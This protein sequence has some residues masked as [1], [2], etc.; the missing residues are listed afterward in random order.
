MA[1]FRTSGKQYSTTGKQFGSSVG[2][3]GGAQVSAPAPAPAAAPSA[4]AQPMQT[5]A[6]QGRSAPANL[7]N[8]SGNLISAG[9]NSLQSYAPSAA[10]YYSSAPA[11]LPS[12]TAQSSSLSPQAAP[13]ATQA[14]TAGSTTQAAPVVNQGYLG[15]II[16]DQYLNYNA[17]TKTWEG[18][19]ASAGRAMD[20]LSYAFNNPFDAIGVARDPNISMNDIVKAHFE[21]SA[22]ERNIETLG[23]T[24]GYVTAIIAGYTAL[25][26]LGNLAL[27]AGGPEAI[28]AANTPQAAGVVSKTVQAAGQVAVNTAT[29]TSVIKSIVGLSL[30]TKLSTVGGILTLVSVATA[31]GLST[32]DKKTD[33]IKKSGELAVNLK[34]LGMNSEADALNKMNVDLRDG[35]DKVRGYIPIFGKAWEGS[36]INHYIEILDEYDL[37]YKAAVK[38]ANEKEELDMLAYKEAKEGKDRV[39]AEEQKQEQRR[40]NEERELEQRGYSEQRLDESR[41]YNEQQQEEERKRQEEAAAGAEATSVEASGSSTLN[42]GLLN[43]SGDIEYVDRDKASQYYFEKPFEEL[44]PAQK[45]LL[46][47]SKGK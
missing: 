43:S 47:L 3:A 32:D 8:S 38:E 34:Q 15:N 25:T 18:A 36:K 45:K 16:P 4:A 41:A 1:K 12:P 20:T 13:A 19:F 29:K 7:F 17:Q 21:K 2:S 33:F 6:S 42:F 5:F 27:S 35:F 30:G 39:Y 46:M 14:P 24:A 31:G 28:A 40:Y 37:K 10:G 44:T 22:S 9:T 23:A 26:A 11:N